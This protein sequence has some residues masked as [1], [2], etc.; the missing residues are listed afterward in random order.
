MG[1]GSEMGRDKCWLPALDSSPELSPSCS[2]QPSY[3]PLSRY[4]NFYLS[5]PSPPELSLAPSSPADPQT[6][7]LFHILISPPIPQLIPQNLILPPFHIPRF[8]PSAFCPTLP[9]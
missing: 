1:P 9:A 2:P 5:D 8:S 6:I 4:P 3:C 7:L